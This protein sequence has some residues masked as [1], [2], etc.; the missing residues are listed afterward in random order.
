MRLLIISFL[1][2]SACAVGPK[3]VTMDAFYD[4]PIGAT[5]AEVVAKTGDP[6]SITNKD[7]GV[8]EYHY[9]ERFKAGARTLEERHYIITLKDGVVI[10]KRVEQISPPDA[11]MHFDSYQMQTTR[12]SETT[13]P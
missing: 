11:P 3:I 5:K 10:S 8:Q 12:N 2:L 13:I 6:S 7:D 1:I 4:V 9:I